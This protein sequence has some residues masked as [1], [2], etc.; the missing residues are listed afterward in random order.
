MLEAK[1]LTSIRNG[2][3]VQEKINFCL[4]AGSLLKITGPNGVGKSTLLKMICG[5]LPISKGSLHFKNKKIN[6][7]RNFYKK[8]I[9]YIGHKNPLKD[10]LTCVENS[11]FLSNFLNITNLKYRKRFDVQKYENKLISECSEGQKKKVVL[12]SILDE[13]KKIWLLDEP[14][15]NLDK[16]SVESFLDIIQEKMNNHGIIILVTHSQISI[17]KSKELIL[18]FSKNNYCRDQILDN[19]F[20]NGEWE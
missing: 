8:N 11:I 13:N 2:R 15:A 7:N 5:L 18:S 14:F 16:K 10:N 6:D 12:S 17:K 4:E 9:C 3:L 20:L 19:P 1:S